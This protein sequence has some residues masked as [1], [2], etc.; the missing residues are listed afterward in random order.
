MEEVKVRAEINEIEKNN[1]M[2]A[3]SLEGTAKVLRGPIRHCYLWKRP[4]NPYV[5][6]GKLQWLPIVVG[7]YNCVVFPHKDERQQQDFILNVLRYIFYSEIGIGISA[8]IILLLFHTLIFLLQ[9]RPRP[10]DLATGHL[11][12]VQ[13]IMLLTGGVI[14]T[15]KFWSQDVINNFSLMSTL[16]MNRMTRQLSILTTCQ[17][18]ILQAITLS[19]RSSCLAKFKPQSSQRVLY[20]FCFL[21]AF[22]MFPSPRILSVVSSFNHT[23]A[24]TGVVDDTCSLPPLSYFIQHLF[25]SLK[26][27]LD[28]VLVVLMGLASGYMATLLCRHRKQTQHLHSTSLSPRASPEVSATQTILLLMALFV[29]V[30]CLDSVLSSFSL[31]MLWSNG[32][33]ILSFQKLVSYGYASF[34]PLMLIYT[35][36]RIIVFLKSCWGKCCKCTIIQ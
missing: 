35:E 13:T 7:D 22:S 3:D 28:A 18:S 4:V 20:S 11:A 29:G 32:S 30:Y 23:T 1:E 17:L 19:P 27:L 6:Y 34:S 31:G 9:S 14:A 33:V 10:T 36:K 26:T 5:D 2:R 8:N 16:Y 25:A 15:N 21:W 24:A 12:F